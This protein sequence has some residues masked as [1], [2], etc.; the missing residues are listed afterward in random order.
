MDLARSFFEYDDGSKPA[1]QCQSGALVE[2]WS[3]PPTPCD[4][5]AQVAQDDFLPFCCDDVD[6]PIRQPHSDLRLQPDQIHIRHPTG[7]LYGDSQAGAQT[8]KGKH[9]ALF[10][11]YHCGPCFST[12]SETTCP[13]SLVP[14]ASFTDNSC[15]SSF[16]NFDYLE[17][18][19]SA[20]SMPRSPCPPVEPQMTIMEHYARLKTHSS[21]HI[22]IGV[23]H[24]DTSNVSSASSQCKDTS[25]K[26]IFQHPWVATHLQD[27]SSCFSAGKAEEHLTHLLDLKR[28][29]SGSLSISHDSHAPS[30]STPTDSASP[31]DLQDLQ[32]V[33]QDGAVQPQSTP[34]ASTFSTVLPFCPSEHTAPMAFRD[35]PP[36]YTDPP[37][38][39]Q[40]A[41]AGPAFS[42]DPATSPQP[43]RKA[44]ARRQLKYSE[45]ASTE[46]DPK[47]KTPHGKGKYDEEQ[48]LGLHRL[49]PRTACEKE[50]QMHEDQEFS[51]AELRSGNRRCKHH[52]PW[53]LEETLTLI[54]GVEDCGGGKW[55]DIKKRKYKSI[56]N[57]SAVDLK[58][59]WRNLMRVAVL[60]AAA[61]RTKCAKRRELPLEVL[62][63]TPSFDPSVIF[64]ERV[65]RLRHGRVRL[66]FLPLLKL[67]CQILESP[68]NHFLTRL[69]I[70]DVSHG[71]M[72]SRHDVL[73][74]ELS[75]TVVWPSARIRTLT[76][77][78]AVQLG[79]V[80]GRLL[81]L[82]ASPDLA[83]I[84]PGHFT[85]G[86][87]VGR[88]PA[89]VTADDG[90]EEEEEK[91]H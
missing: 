18:L 12:G 74:S 71:Q 22:H 62:V 69:R 84:V 33:S 82:P 67:M 75:E 9:G 40:K 76:L 70:Q 60:P 79:D 49:R 73:L 37:L 32:F 66:P 44:S 88:G 3:L 89:G 68:S 17:H 30:S 4:A 31:S 56:E 59:K 27:L 48:A 36:F 65:A 80:D 15:N 61:L 81:P 42:C 21:D 10:F 54:R 24:S 83:G 29:G 23:V 52:N 47:L 46:S 20:F 25:M 43:V 45:L 2:R 53:T 1:V 72:F 57:R 41:P 78:C 38:S 34:V 26:E 8:H 50:L 35:S 90:A 85:Y 58:D 64:E 77:Y 51:D 28:K 55:A 5:F 16:S 87:Q 14:E 19:G 91:Y 13:Q 7:S 63:K 86:G 6:F 11:E 39:E